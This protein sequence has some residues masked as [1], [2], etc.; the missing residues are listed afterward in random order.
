[1]QAIVIHGMARTPLSMGI[2]A[3]RLEKAGIRS[4]SFLYSVTFESWQRC[5]NRLQT[6][7]ENK[8]TDKDFIIVGH[9][10]GCVLTRAVLP[11]LKKPPLGCFFLAPPNRACIA[12]RVFAP[13]LLYKLITG[14]M[15]QLLANEQFMQSLPI[16]SMFTK[17]YAGTVDWNNFLVPFEKE[18]ND[19]ILTVSETILPSAQLQTIP[20]S[21]TFIMNSKAVFSDILKTIHTLQLS[22]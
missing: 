12:A 7:I 4:S 3:W 8:I 13:N 17:I 15:G 1:M 5:L 22:S 20:A 16:P 6:F 11:L 21:H 9:S 19:G 14:E 10:L 2:L 18:P